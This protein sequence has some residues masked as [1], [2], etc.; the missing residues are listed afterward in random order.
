MFK[1]VMPSQFLSI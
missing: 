1:L